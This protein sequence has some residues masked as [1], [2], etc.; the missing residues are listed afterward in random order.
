MKGTIESVIWVTFS[1][2]GTHKYPA[3][4]DIEGVEFLAYPHRHIFH[5]RVSIEVFHDD[6]E[7]EFILFKRE[8]ESLFDQG[9]MDIDYKSCEMLARDIVGY[10]SDKY[11]NRKITV[12]VSEDNENGAELKYTPEGN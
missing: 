1:K 7:L 10:T 12:S 6:R 9:T 4:K 5:F 3:A 8:L 2:E 11:P